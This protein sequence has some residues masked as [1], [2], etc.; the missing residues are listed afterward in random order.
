MTSYWD[1][2]YQQVR[3]L[4]DSECSGP[5]LS[6]K[7]VKQYQVP[8]F[9]RSTSLVVDQFDDSICYDIWY[10]F[11]YLPN[12]NLNYHWSRESFEVGPIDDEYDIMMP[13]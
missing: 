4:L 1:N 13:W 5:M 11:P 12:L 3:V 2:K 9:E 7:I 6:S 8:E 10:S